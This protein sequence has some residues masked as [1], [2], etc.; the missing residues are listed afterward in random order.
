MTVVALA[1]RRIDAVGAPARFPLDQAPRVSKR[2]DRLL[3]QLRPA[4]LICSAA[5][6]AD[7]LALE[8][9]QSLNIPVTIVL[10]FALDRFRETSV[11]DRPGDWGPRFDAVMARATGA[12]GRIQ[13]IASRSGDD[14][15][16]YVAATDAI[17]DRAQRLAVGTASEENGLVAVVVWDG[18]SRGEGDL[19]HYF[20]R[21]A[22]R[23]G[24]QIRRIS[25][26]RPAR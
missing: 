1:G 15:D 12:A 3:R 19:T 26:T 6:G 17:L 16:A 10:P 25:T 24:F 9:A 21:S 14:D 13:V 2:L 11:V 23:R 4:A 20:R 5:C 8:V 7:L 18:V 22:R